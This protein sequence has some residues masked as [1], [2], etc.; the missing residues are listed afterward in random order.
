ML[1]QMLVKSALVGKLL[2]ANGKPSV[3]AQPQE[4][5]GQAALVACRVPTLERR[6]F[7]GAI[8][9]AALDTQD[10]LRY[11]RL[12]PSRTLAGGLGSPPSACVPAS[13]GRER[14]LLGPARDPRLVVLSWTRASAFQKRFVLFCTRQALLHS[15]EHTFL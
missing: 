8:S 7:Y 15:L 4:Y 3:G 9:S 6:A 5:G 10:N 14:R 2:P 13:S 1:S 12:F 11:S